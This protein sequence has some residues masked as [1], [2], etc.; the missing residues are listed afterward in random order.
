MTAKTL[1]AD[2]AESVR[3]HPLRLLYRRTLSSATRKKCSFN[4]EAGLAGFEGLMAAPAGGFEAL[5]AFV[6]TIPT[7]EPEVFEISAEASALSVG[8][9]GSRCEQA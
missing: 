6:G 4:W 8:C 9:E 2:A 1:S 7:V 3:Q 5:K